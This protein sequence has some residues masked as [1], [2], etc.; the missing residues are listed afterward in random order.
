M[1]G[2]LDFLNMLTN[3]LGGSGQDGDPSEM[4]GA[5]DKAC[6]YEPDV[7][8]QFPSQPSAYPDQIQKR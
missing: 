7:P 2:F 4:H 8:Y 6:D 5:Q 3:L 1:G